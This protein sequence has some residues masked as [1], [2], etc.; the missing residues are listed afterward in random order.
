M[1]A[2]QGYSPLRQS[3]DVDESDADAAEARARAF[4][5][6]PSE[7][8]RWPEQ[9]ASLLSRLG[10]RWYDPMIALGNRAHVMADDLWAV[11]PANSSHENLVKF[12]AM[13]EDEVA[14]ARRASR[15]ANILRPVVRFARPMILKAAALQVFAVCFQFARPLLVQQILLLVEGDPAALVAQEDGWTLALALMVATVCDFM[16]SQHQG[17]LQYKQQVRVRAALV[18]LLYRQVV[19]LSSGTKEAYSSGRITNMMDTDQS[20]LQTFTTQLNR[21]WQVP[22]TFTLALIMAIRQLGWA[23]A[24]GV[25]C[26]IMLGP[27]TRVVIAYLRKYK[28]MRNTA[29]D[30]RLK[31]LTEVMQGIRIIKFMNWEESF[32][33]RIGVLRKDEVYAS[34]MAAITR[35]VYTA[36]SEF[37][38]LL[39][40]IVSLGTYSAV[41]GHTLTASVAFPT[42]NFLSI[43]RGPLVQ[44]PDGESQAPYNVLSTVHAPCLTLNVGAGAL[45]AKLGNGRGCCGC[46]EDLSVPIRGRRSGLCAANGRGGREQLRTARDR[47][48]VGRVQLGGSARADPVGSSGGQVRAVWR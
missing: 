25:L 32:C 13:W 29:V 23:G 3:E 20:I 36:F 7:R 14:A 43:L 44:F 10:F 45:S 40:L 24:I 35:S 18:G 28:K 9:E 26:M 16:C 48:A 5:G 31:V 27:S 4:A 34:R 17:W 8:V 42:L 37:Q 22:L 39:I 2:K 46:G 30:G 11:A 15:R 12:E 21:L 33:G 47:R 41:F 19:Q 38:P 6:C 1:S